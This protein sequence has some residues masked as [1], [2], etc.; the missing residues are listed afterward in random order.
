MGKPMTACLVSDFFRTGFNPEENIKMCAGIIKNRLAAFEDAKKD[1]LKKVRGLRDELKDEKK[2]LKLMIRIA[3]ESHD[4][5][6][7]VDFIT[8]DAINQLSK[9]IQQKEKLNYGLSHEHVVPCEVVYQEIL[10][11]PNNVQHILK[12]LSYR[13]LI[14]SKQ[15]E[16]L[17]KTLKL[18]RKMPDPDGWI[19]GGVYDVLA[20]YREAKP[21][22]SPLIGQLHA[23][24]SRGK[25]I[26]NPSS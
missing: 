18:Q 4:H 5:L 21:G 10:A 20:R 1:E 19:K 12:S 16:M 7:T 9:N 17:D 8:E 25:A 23:I 11:N 14:S 2:L 3:S 15:R 22:E 26:L 13:A 24:S 6:R